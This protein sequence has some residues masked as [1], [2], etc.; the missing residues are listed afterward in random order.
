MKMSLKKIA[1]ALLITTFSSAVL[2]SAAHANNPLPTIKADAPNR[3]VVKKGD[4]LWDISGR[5]LDHPWRW[6]EIWATNKQIKNPHLIYPDDILILCVIRG[7]TLVGVD[8]GEG[9]AGVEKQLTGDVV[10]STVTITSTAN[11]ISAIPRSAIQ[12][13]LDK[14]VIVNPED[15]NTTPYVLASKKR[16]LITA[17]GDKIYTKGVP[18]IVGQRYG[19]YREGERYVDPKTKEVIGL[20]V[21]QVATG[22]VTNVAENG[23]SSVQLTDSYGKEVREGDRVFVE[24]ENSIPPIFYPEPASVSR[25]GLIVRVMD[26]ISSA[27]KGS[28]VAINLGSAQGAKPGDVLTVY[29]RGPLVRDTKDNDTPVRLPSEESGMLMVFNTFDNISYAYVLS[30]EL[31][32]NVGDKLLPPPYL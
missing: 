21:T 8:T 17:S 18:L 6:K 20:E 24:L 23:V 30:S 25:G 32:L 28:V 29:Q 15:F 10:A 16:N 2:M 1:K 14:S 4:T 27:A 19:V 12:H 26:S 11:S 3:Y 5:Y 22:V 13:W 31:P 9:C 7:K